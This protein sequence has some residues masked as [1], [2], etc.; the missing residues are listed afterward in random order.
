MKN[1]FLKEE[2]HF[3][4]GA[5]S[6]WRELKYVGGVVYQFVKGFRALHFIGPCITVFGSARFKEDHPYY[7]L[8]RDVSSKVS[9]L[10]FTVMTGGG[11]GIM[12]AAN[13]G[14]QEA[15]GPSVGCN[16]VLPHEQ[17]PNPYLDKYVNIEYFFVRKELLRK[18]SFGIITLPG[19]F[20]T[21]DELFETIT[22]IQTG[23]IKRFPVV[24]MG[25]EYHQHIQ[26]HIRTMTLEGTISPDDEELILFTDDVDEAIE[27]IRRHAEKSKILKLQPPRKANWVLGEK[28]LKRQA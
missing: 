8:A 11:P 12:E 6:R 7:Q 9:Q 25:I 24:I 10:G 13:R 26:E 20:G 15:G 28:S 17:H 27:H 19:G 16:I 3:M 22:L 23:K 2:F 18:Y 1:I 21:L 4:E 5:R 14:A